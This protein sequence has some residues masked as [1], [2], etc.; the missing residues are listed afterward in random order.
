M[1]CQFGLKAYK[2]LQHN[3]DPSYHI[4][5]QYLQN[6]MLAAT[7]CCGLRFQERLLP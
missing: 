3:A 4:F 6:S 2:L 1:A 5:G 7:S